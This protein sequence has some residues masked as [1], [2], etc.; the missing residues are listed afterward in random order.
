[1]RIARAVEDEELV[2]LAMREHG[3]ALAALGRF[4]EALQ[5]LDGA[6]SRFT[7]LA[8]TA[9]LVAVWTA[10]AE[11]CLLAGR[12]DE[13]ASAL[14]RAEDVHSEVGR[15]AAHQ[16]ITRVRGFLALAAGRT[17]D[18]AAAFA[19]VVSGAGSTAD[20]REAG[21]AHLGLALLAGDVED[22]RAHLDA[23]RALLEPLGV[24]VTATT[25]ARR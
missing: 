25:P 1:V 23:S 3:R 10:E 22:E 24:T 16:S 6:R 17:Q 4:D 8:A 15:L 12:D 9:E 5:Q 14:R 7:A 2:A 11:C 18:A 19:E 13:A 21:F 20:A